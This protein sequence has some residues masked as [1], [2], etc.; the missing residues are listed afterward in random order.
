M[1]WLRV[2][3]IAGPA[4]IL[5]ALGPSHP[6]D[7]TPA[8]AGWWTTLHLIL[9]VLFPL[10]GVSLWLLL[11]GLT[12][13]IAWLGRAGAVSYIAFYTALDVLAGVGAGTL[14]QRGFAPDSPAVDAMFETG[15]DLAIIGTISFLIAAQATGAALVIGVDRRFWPGAVILVAAS[16]PFL[17]S[18]IYWPVGVLTLIG[19]AAGLGLLAWG[20]R[21]R[22]S[23]EQATAPGAAGTG[24]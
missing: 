2:M 21:A 4:V 15:N 12:G 10:L 18:H 24:W 7:L 22:P 11:E 16:V 19:L 3:L 17:Y 8:T 20:T 23:G 14:V 1:A 5:A 13:P 6:D 9:L